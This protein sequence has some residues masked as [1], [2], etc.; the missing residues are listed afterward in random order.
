M[1]QE[2]K[3]FSLIQIN[4]SIPMLRKQLDMFLAFSFQEFSP[5]FLS[6]SKKK[7][8]KTYYYQVMFMKCKYLLWFW[9]LI[10]VSHHKQDLFEI[11]YKLK[12]N[13]LHGYK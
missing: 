1:S 8:L 4:G 12:R 2:Q 10:F 7:S 11:N 5:S 3:E 13:T 9:K 6:I